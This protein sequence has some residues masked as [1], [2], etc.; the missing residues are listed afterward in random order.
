MAVYDQKEFGVFDSFNGLPLHALVLHTAVIAIP[1]AT[2][3]AVLFGIPRT[4]SWARW[5]LAVV[6]VGTLG[7]TYVTRQSGLA[8]EKALGIRPG[9]PVG[10][11]ITK[12]SQLATQLLIIVIVFTVL[13]L[14]AVFLVSRKPAANAAGRRL[15]DVAL[16]LLL[17]AA[18]VVMSI[19]VVRVGDLGARAVWNPEGKTSYSSTSQR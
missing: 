19:W 2:L 7:V 5:P 10:N 18:G 4:R 9:N 11:L 14:A 8:L 3:L 13:A 12:H 16:P 15:L 1:L 17:I 6:A